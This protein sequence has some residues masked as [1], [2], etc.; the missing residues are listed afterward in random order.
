VG[1]GPHNFS[2]TARSGSSTATAS[3]SFTVHAAGVPPCGV[4]IVNHAAVLNGQAEIDGSLQILLP[5]DMAMNGQASISGQLLVPGNPALRLNGNP[6][7][8]T[9]GAGTGPSNYA[10]TLNGQAVVVGGLVRNA[11]HAG[12][13]PVPA[14]TSSNVDFISNGKNERV[15]L[16]AG[17]YRNVTIHGKNTLVLTGGT[18]SIQKLTINGDNDVEVAAPVVINVR[19]GVK[20]NGQFGTTGRPDLVTL[21]ISNGGLTLDG[22]ASFHGFV[23]AP[24]GE[25]RLNGQDLLEGGL[26]ADRLTINGQG[27]VDLCN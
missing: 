12:L 13:M 1:V 8:G 10:I 26:I 3:I 17:T 2:V 9:V 11:T 25:V 22:K 24:N 23:T 5:E 18:Y 20:T 15:E 27:I 4:A 21:N 19:D 14:P 7:V 16:P 6:L